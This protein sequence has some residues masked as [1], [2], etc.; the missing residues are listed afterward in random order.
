MSELRVALVAEGD[1]DRV[2]IEAALRAILL[3]PFILVQLQPE[4]TYPDFGGG[5][6]GVFKWCRAFAASGVARLEDDPR[7]LGFDIFIIHLDADVANKSYADGGGRLLEAA[8]AMP[9][10]P[11]FRPCPPPSDTVCDLQ[12]RLLGWMEMRTIG[13]R[14]VLCIPS[15]CSEAWL[16]AAIVPQGDPLHT[17]LECRQDLV[18]R[19]RQ[20]PKARRIRKSVRDYQTHAP[21]VTDRWPQVRQCCTQAQLFQETVERVVATLGGQ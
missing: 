10:L 9:A 6:C 19:F 20:L 15:K 5:W 17:N 3:V 2:L 11:C 8:I 14:T 7:L 12:T 1:T 21:T 16:T 18:D 13:P 4:V